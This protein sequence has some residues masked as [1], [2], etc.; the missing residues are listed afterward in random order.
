MKPIS[1][2]TLHG[3]RS[4]SALSTILVVTLLSSTAFAWPGGAA[5]ATKQPPMPASRRTQLLKLARSLKRSEK[6]L[7]ESN[8]RAFAKSQPN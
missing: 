4:L 1:R 3:R 5:G 7:V 8:S 2:R 6:L